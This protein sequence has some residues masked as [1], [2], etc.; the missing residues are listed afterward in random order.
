MLRRQAPGV[1][2][3]GTGKQNMRFAVWRRIWQASERS[4]F[5]KQNDGA[6]VRCPAAVSRAG[7]GVA[8]ASPGNGVPGAATLP[9]WTTRGL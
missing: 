9:A 8:Q 6:Q 1:N 7:S 4:G 2:C 5:G 3:A